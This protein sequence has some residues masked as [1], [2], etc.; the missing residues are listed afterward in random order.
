LIQSGDAP[1]GTSGSS[2]FMP[3]V[4]INTAGSIGMTFDES[5][6]SEYWSM[7]V[8]ERTASDTPG[9]MEAPVLAQAG[10]AKSPDSR[11]GDFSSTSVDPTDGLTF[12]SANEYQ[13]ADFWDTHIASFSIA[14]AIA[15]PL[16]TVTLSNPRVPQAVGTPALP[17]ASL[18]IA[19]PLIPAAFPNPGAPQA[20]TT[21]TTSSASVADEAV[22]NQPIGSYAP[23]IAAFGAHLRRSQ[24]LDWLW[25]NLAP[26]DL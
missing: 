2:Q 8:T 4:N 1:A 9:T 7:Y 11:V 13:G 15:Q 23:S 26:S 17:S 3:S 21:T 10:T 5:S 6:S 22:P 25:S 19:Q 12:W 14:G 20:G 24:K 18:A 16:N